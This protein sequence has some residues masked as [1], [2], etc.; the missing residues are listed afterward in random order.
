MENVFEYLT[1]IAENFMNMTVGEKF[2]FLENYLK[3][4][5]VKLSDVEDDLKQMNL[6]ITI[7]KIS[8]KNAVRKFTAQPYITHPARV[9]F[10]FLVLNKSLYREFCIYT[11]KELWKVMIE[12][13]TT[14]YLH[15]VV[16]DTDCDYLKL[17]EQGISRKIVKN[18]W[19]LTD[20]HDKKLNRKNRKLS[21]LF[22]YEMAPSLIKLMK[23]SDIFDNVPSMMD[24]DVEFSK[25]YTLECKKIL[26]LISDSYYKTTNFIKAFD[27][28]NSLIIN[29]N[30]ENKLSF[31]ELYARFIINLHDDI[32]GLSISNNVYYVYGKSG[33]TNCEHAVNF[34][35]NSRVP[36]V[37]LD[38]SK[39]D[40]LFSLLDKIENSCNMTYGEMLN[41]VDKIILP[42]IFIDNIDKNRID[43]YDE[44]VNHFLD[45]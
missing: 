9:A 37:F 39:Q 22:R 10:S 1:G 7:C 3:T 13:M 43:G 27:F 23:F 19:F 44:L 25:I 28:L 32:E 29:K 35:K 2:T 34:L 14:L 18:V 17:L 38:V 8:H 45:K 26:D 4:K 42:Q 40:N 11:E 30:I 6:A 16:E 33:C 24:N 41:Y 31:D 12:G 5:T 15:D 36:F 21:T 20:L